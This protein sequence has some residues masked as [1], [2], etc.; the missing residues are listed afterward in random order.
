MLPTTASGT[1]RRA[2]RTSPAGT[3]A[4]SNPD[5][6]KM[7]RKAAL[8]ASSAT[9][10]SGAAGANRSPATANRSSGAIF[11]IESAVEV[12]PPALTPSQL[13]SPRAAISAT[14]IGTRAGA[15]AGTKRTS[16]PANPTLTAESPST[17]VAM[18]SQ[19]TANPTRL[20]DAS[21]AYTYGPPLRSYIEDS[22]AKQR[23]IRTQRPPQPRTPATLLP[24]P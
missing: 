8:T 7:E 11:T 14:A 4:Y 22:S 3:A 18:P 9:S 19:P 21:R 10:A 1:V 16:A 6:M 13:I 2:S 24:P 5:I 20:P 23:A 12:R 17:P 15:A